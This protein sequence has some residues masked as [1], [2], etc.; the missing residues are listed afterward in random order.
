MIFTL[1]KQYILKNIFFTFSPGSSFVILLT[2]DHLRENIIFTSVVLASEIVRKWRTTC[3]FIE[4]NELTGQSQATGKHNVHKNSFL[5]RVS[6]YKNTKGSNKFPPV[7][8]KIKQNTKRNISYNK[9][10]SENVCRANP[11]WQCTW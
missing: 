9:Y 4:N 8:Y 2:C 6:S 10:I 11:K 5:L 1:S 7:W 3:I